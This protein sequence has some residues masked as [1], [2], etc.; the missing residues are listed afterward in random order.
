MTGELSFLP[1]HA[2]GKYGDGKVRCAADYVVSSYVPSLSALTKARKN[3]QPVP[4]ARL[5]G[6]LICEAF[7]RPRYL[8]NVQEE[9]RIARE[10]FEGASLAVTSSASEHTTLSD[11]HSMLDN[12]AAHIL[13]LACHGVQDEDPLKSAFLLEDGRLTVQDI[14]KLDLPHSV[15]AFLSACETAKGHP[16]Q[17]DQAI[18]L[19][20]S[21]LFC[22]F[23]SVIA[24]M[25]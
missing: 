10:A 23:R 19:A 17:P 25:W 4:R 18:H 3:W 24:T 5:A 7:V 15:L 20:A 2:A 22:G 11:A 9:V 14:M 1:I 6:L 8:A 12:A 16:D 21:M 13:H